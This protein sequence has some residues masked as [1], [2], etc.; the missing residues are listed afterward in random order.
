MARSESNSIAGKQTYPDLNL[1]QYPDNI[2]T[3]ANNQNMKGFENLKDYT[4]AE[5]VNAL[6]DAIMAIQRALGI[7]P[8]V[9]KDGVAKTNVSDRIVDLENRDYDSRY[10]GSGWSLS[11]TLIGHTH[12]GGPGHPS[13]VRLDSETQG[14]LPKAKLSFDA[15]SGGISG[16]D[17]SVS[18]TDSRKIPDAIND[19]LSV[20]QGGTIQK[21]LTVNG[22]F[23][24]RTYREWVA[25]EIGGTLITD[26]SASTNQ[27]RRGSGTAETWFMNTGVWNMLYG[28]YVIAYRIRTSSKVNEEIF[29]TGFYDY[30]SSGWT[31]RNGIS[32]KGTDFDYNGQWKTFYQTVEHSG[33]RADSYIA[34][35]AVR[36]ATQASI[37]V[38]IDCIYMMPTHPAIYDK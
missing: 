12:T 23:A 27:A 20:T 33:D 9:N 21:D 7:K 4:L 10:G 24:S 11:Q 34:L 19:K 6:E 25:G 38:D 35:H 36:S 30:T 37:D 16:A 31:W 3:R 2:D 13:Q 26:Y 15:V 1:T 32:I 8:F 29:R 28:K 14:V 18:S 5:H 17:L 22:H